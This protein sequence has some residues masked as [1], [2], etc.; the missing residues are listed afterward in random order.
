MPLDIRVL[1]GTVV[2]A[3]RTVGAADTS[4]ENASVIVTGGTLTITGPHT[5]RDL[6]VLNGAKVTHPDTTATE[7]Y[8][9]ELTLQRDLYVGCGATIDVD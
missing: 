9:L 5:F 2:S 6:V 4:L 8:K 1:Q 3:N 7:V